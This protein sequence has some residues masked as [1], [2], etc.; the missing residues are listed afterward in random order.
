MYSLKQVDPLAT[1]KMEEFYKQYGSDLRFSMQ[2]PM[3][4]D[5]DK[6]IKQA[7]KFKKPFK[8][9]LINY[10]DQKGYRR[11]SHFYQKCG[12][13]RQHFSKIVGW[14]KM[15]P[16]KKTVIVMALVLNLTIEEAEE[17]LSSANYHLSEYNKTDIVV[18][19]CLENE[20]YSLEDVNEALEIFEEEPL[21]Q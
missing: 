11:D 3:R 21:I 17:F 4:G 10:I 7:M 9:Q 12:I 16:Q 6:R 8:N 20:I 18:R 13:T 1:R 5:I 15:I 19:Y 2:G 14:R